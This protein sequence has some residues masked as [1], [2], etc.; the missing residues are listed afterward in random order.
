MDGLL[1]R[2]LISLADLSSAELDLL[3]RDARRLKRDYQEGTLEPHLRGKCIALIFQKP[4]TRTRVSFEA[5]VH[6]LGGH[7]IVLGESE[8]QLKRGETW[9]DTGRVLSR[10]L[11]GI[12]VRTFAEADLE[13]LAAAASV[14]VVNGLTDEEHPCQILADLL[15]VLEWRGKLAG[16]KLAYVGDGNNVA[17]S[18]LLGCALSGMQ[19]ACACPP[20]YEPLPRLVEKARELASADGVTVT[21]DPLEAA[22]L[23]DVIYTDVWTSMGQEETA[24][25]LDAFRP[26]QVNEQL[27]AAASDEVMVM[28]CLPAHRGEEITA[29]VLEG[30]SS[31]VWDQA[32]NRMFAQMAL[33]AALV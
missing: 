20:G 23:A 8:T 33:L 22:R 12:V 3:L 6:Y 21:D 31:A 10:Y 15:T 14:P 11:D 2:D 19:V 26:Y 4:S 30:P 13:E 1:G 28:H 7:A 32:E 29:D 18:L 9:A 24:D 5:G 17:N 25:K 27:L 16:L